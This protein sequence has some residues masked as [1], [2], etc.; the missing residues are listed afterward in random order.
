MQK[1]VIVIST[2]QDRFDRPFCPKSLQSCPRVSLFFLS[3]SSHPPK[4]IPPTWVSS[5]GASASTTL[6]GVTASTISE[7]ASQIP[8]AMIWR[9]VVSPCD[10]FPCA[11]S[12]VM[13]EAYWRFG[14]CRSNSRKA[15]PELRHFDW[16]SP[17]DRSH[18]TCH[19]IFWLC[20][21]QERSVQSTYLPGR[22]SCSVLLAELGLP[23]LAD[24]HSKTGGFKISD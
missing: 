19:I 1:N 20:Q 8:I 7:K 23:F 11:V 17:T 9:I 24:P 22:L 15:D 16:S 12:Y 18:G 21:Q 6:H 2:P 10:R 4:N 5:A 13:D 3:L 14:S